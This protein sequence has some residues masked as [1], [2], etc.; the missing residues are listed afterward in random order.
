MES[1]V[2]KH[3]KMSGAVRLAGLALLT[4]LVCLTPAAAAGTLVVAPHPDDDIITSAGVVYRSV[5]N[6]V[7]TKVVF[8]TNGDWA[9]IGRGYERQD[10]AAAAQIDFLGMTESNL[11]FLGYPDGYLQDL[12]QNYPNSGDQLTTHNGQSET[13]GTRGLGGAD[14]HTYRF[15]S[16]ASYNRSNI[17]TDLQDIL[18]TYQP[19]HIYVTS[20]V[21]NHT[22]HATTSTLLILALDQAILS[23]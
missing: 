15:G 5:Q 20:E 8:M 2:I 21:E 17:L 1:P 6:G 18:V 19:D 10:E 22:D 7:P 16:A 3:C 23:H 4:V 14:Y 9:G 13:Y 12:D 11:I